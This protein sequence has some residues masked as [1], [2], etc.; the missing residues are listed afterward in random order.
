MKGPGAVSS[1]ITGLL[2]AK[3]LSCDFRKP[4]FELYFRS[5]HYFEPYGYCLLINLCKARKLRC[6]TPIRNNNKYFVRFVE[7]TTADQ[8]RDVQRG[9]ERMPQHFDSK[10]NCSPFSNPKFLGKP[11]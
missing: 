11:A 4:F 1:A 5:N 6:E 8:H 2:S 3:H 9:I 10:L 7:S